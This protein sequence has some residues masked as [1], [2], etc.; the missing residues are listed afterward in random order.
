VLALFRV[1]QKSDKGETGI[2]QDLSIRHY[3]VE[4]EGRGGYRADCG[5]VRHLGRGV[6]MGGFGVGLLLAYYQGYRL[7]PRL[8]HLF[9]WFLLVHLY[10]HLLIT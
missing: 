9:D 6:R 10:A 5:W 8:S 1:A 3:M 4:F 7:L 2:Y